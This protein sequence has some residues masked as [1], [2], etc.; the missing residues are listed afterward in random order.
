MQLSSKHINQQH[1]ILSDFTGG[2]N[3]TTVAEMIAENQLA[4]AVNVELDRATGFLK[5]AGGTA[6]IFQTPKALPIRAL[7][8]DGINNRY[9]FVSGLDVYRT[10]LISYSKIGA[11]TGNLFPVYTA[12]ENGILIASGGKLQ[13]Y[14]GRQLVTLNQS[15]DKC[16]GVYIRAGRVL[17]YHDNEIRYSAI[18]DE[19]DWTEDNNV[20]SASKFVEAGYKDGGEIV[21]MVN[22]SSDILIL[23][24]NHRVY[25]LSGEYPN[26]QIR[27][28][29]R[30]VD[31]L[32]RLAYCAVADSVIVL[33]Q[34]KL[35]AI[36]TT[37][38]YG[39]VKPQ[40]IAA[41]V[42]NL[43]YQLPIDTA[44]TVYVPPLNQV[45]IIGARNRVI[46]YD[47]NF[48]AFFERRF[49][50]H[51]VD[52]VSVHDTVFVVRPN[53]V[54]QLLQGSFYD[55]MY[56]ADAAPLEWRFTAK[57]LVSFNYLFLKRTKITYIPLMDQFGKAEIWIGK[58]DIP[59]SPAP[60]LP[61][62]YGNAEVIYENERQLFPVE[63]NC[64][65]LRQVYRDRCIDIRGVGK[66]SA[67]LLNKIEF[68]IVEV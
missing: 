59:L 8:Y 18:G 26:W 45:W 17:V 41:S 3:A 62:I 38:D 1:M 9:L 19:E 66:G 55:E 15:P 12:W 64:D 20:D 28:V 30:N 31:A 48:N 5:T 39:D 22:L 50:S 37:Q 7:M 25:R 42:V 54:T 29:S 43:F 63:S 23:K 33:G 40:N 61:R 56:S 57:R 52:V 14:N 2:L 16:Y 35:Q 58:V 67:I 6:C 32:N 24:S 21:G 49:N 68:D 10:N 46:V 36:S 13:Y 47:L 60:A 4:E 65:G 27:E 11:L 51:V 53:K 34:N 44:R